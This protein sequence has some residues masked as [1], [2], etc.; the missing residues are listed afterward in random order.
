MTDTG[1]AAV[2]CLCAYFS[3]PAPGVRRLKSRTKS[4]QGEFIVPERSPEDDPLPVPPERPSYE[5]CCRGACDPCIFDVYEE[6]M[7]RYR[8]E[9]KAWQDRNRKREKTDDRAAPR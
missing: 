3:Q 8:A 5:D 6:A 2:A 7:E 9:L 1:D 4:A